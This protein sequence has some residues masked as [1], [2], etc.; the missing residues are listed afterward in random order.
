ME[1]ERR[2][3]PRRGA[4]ELRLVG[5][6]DHVVRWSMHGQTDQWSCGFLLDR[7]NRSI[8]HGSTKGT[9]PVPRFKP[10]V[11]R[12]FEESREREREVTFGLERKVARVFSIFPVPKWPGKCQSLPYD[13]TTPVEKGLGMH[14]E[15]T[16][17]EECAAGWRGYFILF[18][19]LWLTGSHLTTFATSKVLVS[20]CCLLRTRTYI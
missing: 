9:F 16:A 2:D 12:A 14:S 11:L 10:L 4:P 7:A 15:P 20:A 8:V 18:V 13:E 19:I 3:C 1:T 5:R 17:N 6:A